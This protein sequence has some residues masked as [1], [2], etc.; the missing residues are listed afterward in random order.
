[1]VLTRNNTDS[2]LV[3]ASRV[4]RYD[5]QSGDLRLYSILRILSRHCRI[6]FVTQGVKNDLPGMEQAKY[7]N[8]L[9]ELGIVVH[10]ENKGLRQLLQENTFRAAWIEYFFAAEYFLPRLRILQPRCRIIIDTVD[11]HYSRLHSKWL[12][13]GNA[14]DRKIAEETKTRELDIYRK[15]DLLILITEEDREVLLADG[16]KVACALIPNI[17]D[18]VPEVQETAKNHSLVFV[19]GFAHE[20]NIDAVL[21]FCQEIFP[22]IRAKVPDASFTV[23]GSN[24]PEA[25]RDLQSDFVRVTGYVPSTTPYLLGSQI[26]VAP[27]RFG[28]GMKG[29][30][31]EAMAH[32]LPVVTTSVGAS[33]MHLVHRENAMIADTPGGFADSVMDLLQDP[34]LHQRIRRNALEHVQNRF[35]TS[36]VETQILKVL[37]SLDGIPRNP[38]QFSEKLSFL[39]NYYRERAFGRGDSSGRSGYKE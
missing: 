32:G 39:L 9:E 3:I 11:V 18:V 12:L 14:E 37:G 6:H 15:A 13:S 25:V 7:Q 27:L 22:R 10:S 31:G 8:A 5:R 29:K 16:I 35:S 36:H 26:S 1:M 17:H 21:Y 2:L 19:G 24:P 28:A 34:D 30:I 33:G 20:P 38:M 4:P 23:V